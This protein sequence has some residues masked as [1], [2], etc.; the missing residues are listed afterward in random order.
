MST[1]TELRLTPQGLAQNA[2]AADSVAEAVGG[3]ESV[4]EPKMNGWRMLAH[5]GDD[6][7]VRTYT[8]TGNELTGSLPQV[9]AELAENF[10]A[11]TWLDGEAV[12]IEID[13]DGNVAHNWGSVQSVLGSGTARAAS[14]SE[15]V[16]Y[17]VFDLI[18]HGGLDVRRL[19]LRARRGAL[20]TIFAAKG[21]DRVMLIPQQPATQEGHDA[22][23]A[24]GFEGS[25]VKHL[26]APYA[27]GR[28]GRGWRKLKGQWTADAVV[29][30]FKPGEGGFAGYIG[31]VEFGQ[32]EADGT[33]ARRGRCSGMDFP[34]RRWFTENAE[35]L[36]A[37]E[38]VIEFG[39]MGVHPP[40]AEYPH[41]GFI[42]PQFKK[43]RR[44]KDASEV[45]VHDR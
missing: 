32:Y 24:A 12:A 5:V 11:G 40:S 42:S 4:L 43:L 13:A 14:R 19:P 33:M 35:R 1:T 18:S 39:H 9:E 16:T 27:S 10:P 15:K 36:I 37:E 17:A 7:R 6:G 23:L 25:I 31:A 20:E 26:D 28:R 34:T 22:L 3:K 41:G 30:G 8:R 2:E 44:D 38:A 21:F 45:L 29:V